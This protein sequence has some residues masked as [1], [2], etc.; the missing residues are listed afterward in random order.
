M[1]LQGYNFVKSSFKRARRFIF[2]NSK[3]RLIALLGGKKNI[4]NEKMS[5]SKY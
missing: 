1:E 5:Q 4:N 3:V 2:R